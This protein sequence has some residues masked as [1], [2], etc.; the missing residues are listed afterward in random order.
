MAQRRIVEL[1][2]D[3]DET[4]IEDG[5]TTT[6]ALNGTTYE[7]DLSAAN[8]ERLRDALSPFIQA[9]RRVRPGS[10]KKSAPGRSSKQSNTD[11]NAIRTWARNNGYTVSDRGRIAAPI[12]EAYRSA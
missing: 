6:F 1:I 7:I 2:D 4:T 10:A 5:G 12:I 11:L 9:G 8:L 3:L